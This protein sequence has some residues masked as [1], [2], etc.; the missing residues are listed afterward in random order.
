MVVPLLACCNIRL[1]NDILVDFEHY[2]SGGK[3]ADMRRYDYKY[4]TFGVDNNT[5]SHG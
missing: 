2:S 5:D 1:Q 3:Y 4:I